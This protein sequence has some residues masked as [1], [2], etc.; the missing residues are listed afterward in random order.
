MIRSVAVLSVATWVMPSRQNAQ[1]DH[2]P[3]GTDHSVRRQ[4]LPRRVAVHSREP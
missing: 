3:P 4:T 1:S 2:F